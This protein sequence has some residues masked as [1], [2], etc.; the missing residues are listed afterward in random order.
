[1]PRIVDKERK[2]KEIL[3]AAVLV[4]AEKG[5]QKS[6]MIDIARQAK[7]GKGTIYEYFE[8]KEDVFKE[9]YLSHFKE[10][11]ERIFQITRSDE[12]ALLKIQNLTKSILMDFFANNMDFAGIMM[13]FWAEGIRSKDKEILAVINLKEMYALFREVLISVLQQGIDEGTFREM[14]K[15]VVASAIIGSFDGLLLQWILDKDVFDL[16]TVVDEWLKVLIN[17]IK[18]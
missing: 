9:A 6:K 3:Q 13:D 1:M 15:N 16:Q 2:K 8:S 17:G 12:Q 7:I 14:D 10:I 5:I 18:K 11:E 4:F